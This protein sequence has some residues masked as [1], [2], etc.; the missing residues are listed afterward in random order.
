MQL[1][2]GIWFWNREF[3]PG[4]SDSFKRQLLKLQTKYSQV[5]LYVLVI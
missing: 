1:F 3:G 4:T 2:P 5:W